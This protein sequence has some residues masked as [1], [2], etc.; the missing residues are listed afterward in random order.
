MGNPRASSNLAPGTTWVP[1]PTGRGPDLFPTQDGG[2]LSGSGAR[3][4]RLGDDG[5]EA[6]GE[7]VLGPD[8][9]LRAAVLAAHVGTPGIFAEVENLSG[10]EELAASQA[11]D[12]GV[13]DEL[14]G[15]GHRTSSGI[16]KES[17]AAAGGPRVGPTP[18]VGTESAIVQR[19]GWDRP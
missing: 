9:V 2:A 4:G 14:C 17:L 18:I 6:D 12:R 19:G 15:F 5:D 7:A 1:F 3:R 13:A 10:T 16:D 11:L 8:L